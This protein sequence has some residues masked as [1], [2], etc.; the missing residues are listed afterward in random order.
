M[1]T[2]LAAL[3]P[4]CLAA[5]LA[6]AQ[7]PPAAAPSQDRVLKEGRFTEEDIVKA[8]NTPVMRNWTPQVAGSAAIVAAP[9]KAKASILI[10]FVTASAELS[11]QA[12]Q[13]LDVL[14]GAMK[15]EKLAKLRFT[16]EGHADPRGDDAANLKLSQDRA[17]SVRQYLTTTHGLDAERVQSIGKGSSQLM[18]PNQP[19]AAENRRVTIVAEPKS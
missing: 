19:A 17:D 3:L 7:T 1:N 9:P 10:T 6:T 14:A 13:S 16:V 4:L 8:F 2:R 12:R 5:A 11:P 18:R 15:S